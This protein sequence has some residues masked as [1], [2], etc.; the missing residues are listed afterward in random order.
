MGLI[1]SLSLRC[2]CKV[3]IIIDF[4]FDFISLLSVSQCS[5]IALAPR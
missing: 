4:F 1:A 3:G 5:K 2:S